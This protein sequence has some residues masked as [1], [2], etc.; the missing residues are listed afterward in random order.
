MKTT[1][2]L[3]YTV[4]IGAT[5]FFVRLFVFIFA[6]K[7]KSDYIINEV[8]MV[9][10]GLVLSVSNINELEDRVDLS[11]LSKS[12]YIGIS[13]FLLVLFGTFLGI[14]YFA[15]I[16]KHNLV[17]KGRIKTCSAILSVASLLFSYSIYYRQRFEQKITPQ[18]QRT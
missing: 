17:D 1:K 9:T 5:P 3:I 8:D 14:A 16:D 11:P 18:W 4:L 7:L 2:W 12:I 15:D 10:F 13:V 6:T